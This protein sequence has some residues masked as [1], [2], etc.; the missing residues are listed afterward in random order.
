MIACLEALNDECEAQLGA[1]ANVYSVASCDWTQGPGYSRHIYCES[2][3]LSLPGE[4]IRYLAL[5]VDANSVPDLTPDL[6]QYWIDF[7]SL[8]LDLD[9]Y[10]PQGPAEKKAHVYM[11]QRRTT[12]IAKHITK[13]TRSPTW[14]PKTKPQ[15]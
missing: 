14:Q 1:M 6:L 8:F 5:L 3:G 2:A 13:R 4:G 7:C 11:A 10:D 9:N 15:A 12:V